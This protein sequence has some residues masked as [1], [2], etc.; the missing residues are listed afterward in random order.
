MVKIINKNIIIDTNKY[1]NNL[2]F[3]VNRKYI[4]NAGTNKI[5]KDGLIKPETIKKRKKTFIVKK[6]SFSY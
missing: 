1:I 2:I 3:L 5:I 4:V 6:G